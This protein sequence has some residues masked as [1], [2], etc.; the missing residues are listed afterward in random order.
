MFRKLPGPEGQNNLLFTMSDANRKLLEPHLVPTALKH[1]EELEAPNVRPEYVYFLT[2]GIGSVV[3]IRDNGRNVEAGIFGRDGMSGTS[4]V[5]G[6]DSTPHLTNMQVAGDGLRIRSDRLED[7]MHENPDL[8]R[9]LLLFVHYM[10]IQVTQTA[11][12]NSQGT[13]EGRLARWLLMCNDRLQR[14]QVSLTHEFLSVMLGVRSASV[15][16]G[17]HILE[18]KGLIKAN[19]GEIILLDREGLKA[20]AIGYGVAEAAYLKVLGKKVK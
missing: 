5:L 20:E 2:G 10:L 15:T 14:N 4:I 16:V 13:L 17:T 18:G 11:L 19:R 8:Q 6:G 7:L 9:H 12:A 3:A 1:S